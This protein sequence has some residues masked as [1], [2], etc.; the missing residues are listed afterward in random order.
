MGPAR[1]PGKAQDVPPLL[2][3]LSRPPAGVAL[4]AIERDGV[5]CDAFK[6]PGDNG[7]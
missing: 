3:H 4:S 7:R 2:G 1:S 6:Q 5:G